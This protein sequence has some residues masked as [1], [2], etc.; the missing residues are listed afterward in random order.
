MSSRGNDSVRGT[1]LDRADP[2]APEAPVAKRQQ[3]TRSRWLIGLYAGTMVF[4]VLVVCALLYRTNR[5]LLT[6][7]IGAAPAASASGVTRSG[8]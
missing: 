4:L 6:P 8:F 2:T 7:G 1:A 5:W 3:A